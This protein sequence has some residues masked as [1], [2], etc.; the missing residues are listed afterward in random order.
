MQEQLG[1]TIESVV[2]HDA[3]RSV[4]GSILIDGKSISRVSDRLKAEHFDY[5]P[6]RYIYDACVEL[7]SEPEVEIDHQTLRTRLEINGRLDDVGGD[8]YLSHCVSH[9]PHAENIVAYAQTVTNLYTLRRLAEVGRQAEELGMDVT[10]AKDPDAA[11]LMVEELLFR[12][13]AEST[14]KDFVLLKDAPSLVKHESGESDSAEADEANAPITTGLDSMDQYLGGLHRSDLVVVAA[15]PGIGKSTLVL[16]YALNAADPSRIGGSKKVG[17]FSLEMGIEQIVD[18]MAARLSDID[19]S[20]IRKRE[21]PEA[22]IHH[23]DD[24]RNRLVNCKIYVDDSPI[25]TVVAM[26]TKAQRL[27]SMHG[28]DLLIVDYMQLISGSSSG[29]DGNRVQEVSEIS[30]YLK[31]MARDLNVPVVA[32]S[33]LNR[34]V[35][36]RKSNEPRLSDLRESGSIEQDADIVMFIHRDDKNMNEDE[37]YRRNPTLDYPRGLAKIIVAKHRHGPTGDLMLSVRDEIGLFSS[38]PYVENHPN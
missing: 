33:Q 13:G 22:R 24:A 25:Q 19:I 20:T 9:L 4:I 5:E 21:V 28:L 15:R 10:R 18:R 37:W 8:S 26:R 31:A 23:F 34:E 30:R 11:V 38:I 35:E 12:I 3:E 16:N 32:C 1:R 36:H 29:R 2:D 27:K 14:Q 7:M 6:H 17:I